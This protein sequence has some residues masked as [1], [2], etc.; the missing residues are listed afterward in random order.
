MSDVAVERVTPELYLASRSLDD[1]VDVRAALLI[2]TTRAVVIDTL[3]RP[4]DMAEFAVLVD[5]SGLPCVVIDTHAD[6][7]H[8]WG[9]G[10]F[11]KATIVGHT[12]CR[13]RLGGSTAREE[14]SKK[15]RQ[16]PGFYDTVSLTAPNATFETQMTIDAGSFDVVLHHMPGHT[17]DSI[18]AFVPQRKLLFA[19]DC[20]EDPFPLLESGPLD[21]WIAALQSWSQREVDKVIPAHGRISGPELLSANAAYLGGLRAG[22]PSPVTEPAFYVDA[23]RRN[24]AAARLYS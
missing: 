22:P 20:A 2:G 16:R 24:V 8:A 14:L 9:N 4:E 3:A 21:G 19:G 17:G 12:L 6:W 15:R 13:T 11:G 7:D 10:A 23:H 5:R 1:G 18:V